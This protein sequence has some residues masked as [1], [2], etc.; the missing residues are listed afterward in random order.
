MAPFIDNKKNPLWNLNSNNLMLINYHISWITK[1]FFR[2]FDRHSNKTVTLSELLQDINNFS[3]T[4]VDVI[5]KSHEFSFKMVRVITLVASNPVNFVANARL[6]RQGIASWYSMTSR[7][8]A[9]LLLSP[10]SYILYTLASTFQCSKSF[11]SIKVKTT[12]FTWNKVNVV[13]IFVF[14]YRVVF[15][16]TSILLVC[17]CVIDGRPQFMQLRWRVCK[18]RKEMSEK[19][20]RLHKK[21]DSIGILLCATSC[22][23][24]I[25]III[26]TSSAGQ[27]GKNKMVYKL[28]TQPHKHLRHGKTEKQTQGINQRLTALLNPSNVQV[29][30]TV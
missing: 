30:N 27:S 9:I 4:I 29:S 8:S 2:S 26:R 21:Y 15:P 28:S 10:P 16:N 25:I 1:Q 5:R 7:F 22:I 13:S 6:W 24:T 3:K 17:L 11:F 19:C 12:S 14:I 20:G 18:K 23:I